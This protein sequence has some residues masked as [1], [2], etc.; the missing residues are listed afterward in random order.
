M[1]Q[2][3][4]WFGWFILIKLKWF[5]TMYDLQKERFGGI[6]RRPKSNSVRNRGHFLKPYNQTHYYTLCQSLLEHVKKL[7]KKN[8]K[9]YSY[10]GR[11]VLLTVYRVNNFRVVR[12]TLGMITWRLPFFWYFIS[13]VSRSLVPMR[14][15]TASVS[16][17][18]SLAHVPFLADYFFLFV[19][20]WIDLFSNNKI[21]LIVII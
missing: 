10:R 2:W 6:S 11:N 1:F 17:N 9:P 19:Y 3:T 16:T 18:S 15:V 4:I 7:W 20:H 21:N 14:Y 8:C 5:M 13:K 12:N